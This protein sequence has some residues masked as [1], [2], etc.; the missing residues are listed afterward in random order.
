MEPRNKTIL[1]VEIIVGILILIGGVFLVTLEGKAPVVAS[2]SV[3][4]EFAT[5]SSPLLQISLQYPYGWSV[6]PEYNGIPG[7]ERYKGP[8]AM[9]DGRQGYF[10]VD[11]VNSAKA[12]KNSIVKKYPKPIK[13]GTTT[14]RYFLLEGFS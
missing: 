1:I 12:P 4:P 9:P 14:Y 11:A 7:L 8:D 6:D 10:R 13:L 5:Y 3:T 2:P